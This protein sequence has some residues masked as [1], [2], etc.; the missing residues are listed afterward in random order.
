M[1]N[2]KLVSVILST[3]NSSETISTCVES[4]LNQTYKN[5]ELLIVDDC[6]TDNTYEIL[7]EYR[8]NHPQIKLFKNSENIGLTKS[9]NFLINKSKGEFIARQ[10]SDDISYLDRIEKQLKFINTYKLDGCTS[11]ALKD[12]ISITPRLSYYLPLKI[13]IKYKNPFIH[14]TLLIRKSTIE[15]IKNYDERFYFS[16]D[17]KLLTDLLN[18]GYKILIMKDALYNLNTLNNIS[19]KYKEEQEYYANC[20]RKKINPLEEIIK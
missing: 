4:V 16:Q 1:N 17:Y 13:V 5:I 14:G 18:A 19:S 20:V 9:L 10:D 12:G 8:K 15:K 3:F 11:R 2:N 6:S 7:D